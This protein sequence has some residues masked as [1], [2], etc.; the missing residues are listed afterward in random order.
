MPRYI[1]LNRYTQKGVESIEKSPARLDAVRKAFRK[2]GADVKD[3]YLVM[4]RYD[5]VVVAEAPD[6]ETMA[7]LAL[8]VGAL[9]NVHTE[10]L[11]AFTEEEF[12]KITA[13]VP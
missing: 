8:S 2:M 10:T 13:A 5:S 6:D 1:M 7:K 4:G 3:F 9:G 12:R 11:R